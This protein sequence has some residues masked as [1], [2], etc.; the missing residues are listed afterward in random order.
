MRVQGEAPGSLQLA[1][2]VTAEVVTAK[3]LGIFPRQVV[4]VREL[5]APRLAVVTRSG[6][7]HCAPVIGPTPI[8]TG[9]V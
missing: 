2:W 7:A 9:V 8:I 3:E 1:S 5:S 6:D 4:A